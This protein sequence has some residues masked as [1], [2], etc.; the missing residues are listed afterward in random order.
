MTTKNMYCLHSVEVGGHTN[1]KVKNLNCNIKNIEWTGVCIFSKFTHAQG[2]VLSTEIYHCNSFSVPFM[3]LEIIKLYAY[4]CPSLRS[5]SCDGQ[6]WN[7][8]VFLAHFQN[9]CPASYGMLHGMLRW[10]IKKCLGKLTRPNGTIDHYSTTA[11]ASSWT[12]G[13]GEYPVTAGPQQ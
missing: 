12:F 6:K 7:S 8:L 11:I 13:H 4:A 9:L 1:K 5:P 10:K 2:R 3:L